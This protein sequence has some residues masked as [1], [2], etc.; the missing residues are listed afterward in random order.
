MHDV[1]LRIAAAMLLRMWYRSSTRRFFRFSG[2]RNRGVILYP[3]TRYIQQSDT[4][5]SHS[6]CGQCVEPI[7]ARLLSL[8]AVCK[9]T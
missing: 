9:R 3:G 8:H 1:V 5:R 2:G 6:A 7:S 4:S